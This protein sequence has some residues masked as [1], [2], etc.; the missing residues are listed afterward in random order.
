LLEA[1]WRG[2]HE[3]LEVRN[4]TA[5]SLKVVHISMKALCSEINSPVFGIWG[6][7]V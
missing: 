6:K 7:S 1:A 2:F 4:N 3:A 5:I